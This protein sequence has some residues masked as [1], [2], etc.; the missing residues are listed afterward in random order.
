[1][2]CH[3]RHRR[4][5][6]VSMPGSPR[7]RGDFAYWVG[8]M[9]L[10]RNGVFGC[11]PH[12]SCR[13]RPQ[14]PSPWARQRRTG[15]R[16]SSSSTQTQQRRSAQ[17]KSLSRWRAARAQRRCAPPT[18][19]ADR[20]PAARP[21]MRPCHARRSGAAPTP[22]ASPPGCSARRIGGRRRRSSPS[23]PYRSPVGPVSYGCY[24]SADSQH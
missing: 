24:G 7:R 1:V 12:P 5:R 13:C 23:G 20:P 15:R 3:R 4:R 6:D 8:A 22:R 11:W 18:R 10:A 9:Q 21:T 16:C 14:T 17:P 2:A 19:P